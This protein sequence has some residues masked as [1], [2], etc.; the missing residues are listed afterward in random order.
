MEVKN[1]SHHGNFGDC[2]A[3]L[4]ALKEFYRKTGVK[5]NLY[6]VQDHPA[7]YA[8]GVIHPVKNEKGENVSLNESIVKMLIPL[9]KEQGYLGEVKKWE[10]EEIHISLSEIRNTFVNSPWGSLSRWYFYVFP[11]LACD[12]SLKYLSVPPADKNLAIGKIVITRT[13]RYHNERIDYSFLKPLEDEC[14]FIGTMREYNNFCMG[15]DLNI[16]KLHIN[17]F[18]EMAQAIDQSRFHISNQTAAFQISEMLKKPR[19][20]EVCSWAQNVIPVGE[21]AYDFLSQDG[22]EW[23][24]NYLAKKYPA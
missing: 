24:V 19:V 16:E 14:I 6:L 8:E 18:L 21:D 12:L 7:V 22:L 1:F 5:P 10:E 13:E 9:L 11:D 4:P 20:V 17:N 2:L 23:Y 3:S 15:F